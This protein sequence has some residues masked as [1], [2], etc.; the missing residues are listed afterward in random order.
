MARGIAA[1]WEELKFPKDYWAERQRLASIARMQ[2]LFS[3]T[4]QDA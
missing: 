4:G 2:P 1:R 3:L